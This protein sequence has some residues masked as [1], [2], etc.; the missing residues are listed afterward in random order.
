MIKSRE[1]YAN[2][3][4]QTWKIYANPMI[5]LRCGQNLRFKYK[6]NWIKTDMFCNT[7][8]HNQ[9]VKDL[10][11]LL[12]HNSYKYLFCVDKLI[13]FTR[14]YKSYDFQLNLKLSIHLINPTNL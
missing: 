9:Q 4:I 14:I 5:R 7:N 12:F 1:I 3:M 2:H 13:N 6:I 10:F 8:S 11:K